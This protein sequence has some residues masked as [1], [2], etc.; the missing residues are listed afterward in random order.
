MV[1]SDNNNIVN[2]NKTD[3]GN[4]TSPPFL[5]S[6]NYIISKIVMV[7]S[8]NNNIVNSNKTNIGNLTSPPF[9]HRS[10]IL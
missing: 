1:S 7:S 8:D 10:I 6:F 4:F 9:Y 3:I 5:P 2:S